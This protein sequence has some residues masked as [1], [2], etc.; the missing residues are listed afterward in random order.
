MGQPD[1]IHRSPS[2]LRMLLDTLQDQSLLVVTQE[3]VIRQALDL[4]AK[5]DRVTSCR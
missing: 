1:I 5:L 4:Q 3:Q 2:E